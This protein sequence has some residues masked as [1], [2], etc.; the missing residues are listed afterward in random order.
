MPPPVACR[1]HRGRKARAANAGAELATDRFY[2][3][4]VCSVMAP[5]AGLRVGATPVIVSIFVSRVPTVSVISIELPTVPVLTNVSVVPSTTMVSPGAKLVVSEL[6]GDT[7]DSV[8]AAVIGPSDAAWFNAAEPVTVLSPKGVGGVP[9]T[10]GFWLKSEGF[11][12]PAAVS[13]PAT[14]VVL[15]GVDGVVGRFAAY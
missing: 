6:L 2:A 14:A 11:K 13:V 12:P 7:P 4:P 1:R 10:R 3:V 8:V 9:K 15:A 5:V